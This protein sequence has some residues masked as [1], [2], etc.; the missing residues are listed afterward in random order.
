M[1]VRT[2]RKTIL[3]YFSDEFAKASEYEQVEFEVAEPKQKIDEDLE[4]E[5]C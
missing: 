1:G 5:I 2:V 3:E 4:C